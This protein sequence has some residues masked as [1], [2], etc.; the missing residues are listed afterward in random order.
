MLAIEMLYLFVR[1]IIFSTNRVRV[2]IICYYYFILHLLYFQPPLDWKLL[3]G[4]TEAYYLPD[5]SLNF[6]PKHTH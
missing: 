5:S 1:A 4:K 6:P 3:E 2:L